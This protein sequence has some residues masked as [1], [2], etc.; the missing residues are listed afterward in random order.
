MAKQIQEI[1][2]DDLDGGEANETVSFA[3]DGSSYEIDLSDLNAKKLRDALT[4]FVQHAR[5]AGAVTTRRRGRGGNRAMSREK[6]S[7]IRQWAKAHGLPV[8]E[9]G[10]IASTVVEKYEQAH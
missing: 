3:I 4:P 9:R 8:S 6:S 1:L 10:R 2:I 7:E 5:R